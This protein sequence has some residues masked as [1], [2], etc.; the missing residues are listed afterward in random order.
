MVYVKKM[1]QQAAQPAAQMAALLKKAYLPL[2]S[3]KIYTEA[4]KDSTCVRSSEG[5]KG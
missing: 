2:F 5:I 3:I 4:A 1:H